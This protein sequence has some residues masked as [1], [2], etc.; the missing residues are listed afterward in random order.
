MLGVLVT[1]LSV[2]GIVRLA[3]PAVSAHSGVRAQ[4]TFIGDALR[5]GAAAE[6]QRSFP[7]GYFFLYAL[8]GLTW[9]EVGRLEPP[10]ERAEALREA[11]W[12]LAH[13][14]TDEGRAPFSAT[15]TPSHGIFYRGWTNWLRGG[16]L[17]LQP[18]DRRDAGEAQRFA[19][20]SAE[21]ARAFE[22]AAT[23]YLQAYPGQAWPVDS[24]VA[25]AS[26]RLHDTLLPPRYAA[27]ASRWVT[28]VRARL[29]PA[30]GLLPHTA[31][32]E[33]GELGEVARGT[34]QSMITRFLIE[35]DP[36]FA[37][38]QYLRFRD[39]YVTRPLGLGPAVREYPPVVTH[40]TG[41][42]DS[43]PLVLGTS[44][45]ATVVTI[46]AARVQG[47]FALATALASYGELAG[48]PVSTPWTK[49]YGLGVVPVGD[50]FVAWSKVSSAWVAR[51]PAFTAPRAVAWWWPAPLVL[52]L[53]LVAVAPWWRVIRRLRSERTG[54]RT[55][56]RRRYVDTHGGHRG[57]RR[58]ARL[59]RGR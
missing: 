18:P 28:D 16:V 37:R 12:A 54:R 22:A 40:A 3:V 47:D 4:L 59:R 26:L 31:D 48:V 13:L 55:V 6:A 25:M 20:D 1:V 53:L 15:L 2:G 33:T 56:R 42:V 58:Q 45:S 49:R 21:I 32:P 34:S 52:A 38:Q 5:R 50:A 11:R 8:Y 19:D 57:Q 39:L 14:D 29:D 27:V 36:P 43:G 51:P 44:L 7:E 35:I 23:P 24:T 9:V 17:T 41:D 10:S 46:G 30:T